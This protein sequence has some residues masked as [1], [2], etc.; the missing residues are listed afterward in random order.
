MITE[1]QLYFVLMRSNSTKIKPFRQW[2]V[3]EVLPC[4]RKTGSYSIS[5]PK[6]PQSYAEALRELADNVERVAELENKIALDKPKVEYA[7]AILSADNSQSIGDF[8]KFLAAKGVETGQNRFFNWLKA[9]HF[10]QSDNM[11]YQKYVD[12]GYFELLQQSY[13]RGDK[14]LTTYKTLITPKGQHYFTLKLQKS[15]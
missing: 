11:P 13:K 15:A 6:L 9:N 4:I 12:C 2:V 3:S 8:A 7:E 10:L 14:R 5:A 1:S